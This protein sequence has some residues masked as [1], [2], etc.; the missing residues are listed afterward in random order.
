M[1]AQNNRLD[2]FVFLMLPGHYRF[3]S[4]TSQVFYVFVN[5]RPYYQSLCFIAFSITINRGLQYPY[6][7]DQLV[8]EIWIS[9][10]IKQA[11]IPMPN[12][13]VQEKITA[14]L[15]KIQCAIEVEDKLIEA[16]REL[17]QEITAQIFSYG[18]R[19]EE[20]RE[21]EIGLVPGSWDV[22]ALGKLGKI[23]NGSTPKRTN[24]QYWQGGNIPWLTKAEKFTNM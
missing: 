1:A 9:R 16:A 21:T 19:N 2:V 10:P 5:P 11:E 22:V 8:S 18:L 24:P 13:T 23:G 7:E 12:R 17:K 20:P 3:R 4:V 6:N 15:W 14:F